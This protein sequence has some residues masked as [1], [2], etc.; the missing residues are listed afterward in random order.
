MKITIYDVAE[1]AGVS[2]S[3][4]SR[5]INNSGRVSEK[6]KQKVLNIIREMGYQSGVVATALTGTQ[7]VTVGII[8]PNIESPL[9][10]EIVNKANRIGMTQGFNLLICNTD[11]N[12]DLEER[13]LQLLI[14]KNVDGIIIGTNATTYSN[15]RHLLLENLPCVLIVQDMPQVKI[16]V[17]SVDDYLGVYQ[18]VTYFISLGHQKIA[19]ILGNGKRISDNNRF[20]AYKQ[21]MQD[22][23]L[24]YDE[25]LVYY[26]DYSIDGGKCAA[27]ELFKNSPAVTAVFAYNEFLATGVYQAAKE[28]GLTI[29]NDVSVIGFDNTILGRVLDP[30]LTTIAHPTDEI[31]EQAMELLMSEIKGA[32]KIKQRVILPPELIIR[33]STNEMGKINW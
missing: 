4:V 15:S 25:K 3:T 24:E 12:L 27:L 7:N 17:V 18:A 32:K 14:Q 20:Q 33:G 19:C 21:A 28:I 6:T 29:P 31:V 11:N 1:K 2:I 22:N 5:V 30:P 8:I 26:T 9:Y 23:E 10:T 16:D 13:Y